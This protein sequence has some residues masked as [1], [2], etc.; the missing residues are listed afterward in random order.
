MHTHALICSCHVRFGRLNPRCG[1]WRRC[2]CLT[3]RGSKCLRFQ[4]T[5][6]MI[7]RTSHLR[8]W[9]T[10]VNLE[11]T[12]QNYDEKWDDYLDVGKNYKVER[13]DRLN[14]VVSPRLADTSLGGQSPAASTAEVV[15][16]VLLAFFLTPPLS[17][18]LR[19]PPTWHD[20]TWH[21]MTWHDT[22]FIKTERI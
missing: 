4:V 19:F 21:D 14:A 2:S 15:M 8:F 7:Y 10:S 18:L 13:K 22:H 12:F 11:V 5:L 16:P 1:K 9:N 17:F 20:M 6:K 3:L